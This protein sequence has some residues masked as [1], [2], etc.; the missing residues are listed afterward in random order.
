LIVVKQSTRKQVVRV[1]VFNFFSGIKHRGIPLY[2]REIAECMRRVG[3][4]PVELVGP[5]WLRRW[6]ALVQNVMFVLFEQLVAPAIRVLR[7]C[8]FTFYPYNSAGI[9]DAVLGRSAVAVHDLISNN[10]R[11]FGLAARYVRVTQRVHVALR[12]PVCAVSDI[13][14]AQIQRMPRFAGCRIYAWHNPFY[15]F[16]ATVDRQAHECLPQ[17]EGRPPSVLLCTGIGLNKDFRGAIRL[18]CES[19]ALGNVHLR[20]LGFGDEARFARRYLEQVPPDVRQ[21]IIVLE[22]IPLRELVS[23]YLGADVIW[24]HS[25]REGFG[26]NVAEGRI[27]GRPV[28]A[29]NIAAFRRLTWMSVRLYRRDEFERVLAQTLGEALRERSAPLKRVSPARHHAEL[30]QA[31]RDLVASLA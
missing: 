4:Q 3:V 13:T 12:R 5:P 8:S 14:M 6:P 26:R 31:V 20:I 7:G 22:R 23:E 25:A 1:L 2:T 11:A 27:C 15:T 17:P 19:S 30:E 9:I 18:F 29:S 16:E 21:R 10:R 28:V 24:V